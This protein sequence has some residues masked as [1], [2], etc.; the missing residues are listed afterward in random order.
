[1]N[2]ATPRTEPAPIATGDPASGDVVISIDAMGGDRGVA[3]IVRGMAMSLAKNPR[4][5]Y[6]LHGD[7]ALLDP[8]IRKDAGLARRTEVRHAPGVIAMDDKPSR[9]LRNAQ[10]T[11]M[12]SALE[13]VKAGES[14]VVI[15]CGNTGAL[16]ALAMLALRKAP[17]VDRPAIAVLWPSLNAA[18]YS[19]LLDAG[20][21]IR[22]DADDLLK[23]AVMGASYARNAL[24]LRRPRVGL[25]NVGTEEH[26]GRS[27]LHE[28]SERMAEVGP[29]SDFDY[30]GYVEGTDMPS[31]RVDVIVTDGFTGNVALKTGEGTARMIQGLLK[32]AFA[33]SILSRIGALFALTSL[34]RL[35]KRIDPRRVN[36]GV[37]LG[38]NGTV[39]KSH[40]SADATGV[41]AAIKLAFILADH[42]F[43]QR[44]A[45]RVA[46]G[47]AAHA[48]DL[49]RGGL[50]T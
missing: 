1:M 38:L 44:L 37:F 24:G 22:A 31:D 28:A 29:V 10:G 4:L 32:E 36:G 23:Y 16:L 7:R 11:S 6:L 43:T 15:S 46:A 8:A 42:G 2:S 35:Q 27:E 18:G 26:K 25:L 30:I 34:K 40:G 13:A 50:P 3:D 33:Y 41:S 19:V 12:W 49:A 45:A 20:A 21:D 47:P 48:P 5:R 17:G 9:V 39:I 14:P